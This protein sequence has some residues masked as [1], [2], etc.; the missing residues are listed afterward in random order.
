MIKGGNS[1][2]TATRIIYR[3]GVDLHHAAP[4]HATNS[5]DEMVG[6]LGHFRPAKAI[7]SAVGDGSEFKSGMAGAGSSATLER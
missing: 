3:G 6:P 2:Q 5:L 4:P 1:Y 7:V